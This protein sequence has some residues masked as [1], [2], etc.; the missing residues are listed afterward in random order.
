[1]KQIDKYKVEDTNI[2]AGDIVCFIS[3]VGK[4]LNSRT[5]ATGVVKY[6]EKDFAH[7]HVLS[8]G[9]ITRNGWSKVQLKNLI[10]REKRNDQ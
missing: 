9:I 8:N 1:M 7:V 6:I 4:S 3:R 5:I 2:E 10:I